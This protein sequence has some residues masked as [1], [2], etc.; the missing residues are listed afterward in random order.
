VLGIFEN[1]KLEGRNVNVEV[2][3]EGAG[4][5]RG[6]RRRRDDKSFGNKSKDDNFRGDRK[7]DSGK[8]DFSKKDGSKFAGGG[9]RRSGDFKPQGTGG[10]RRRKE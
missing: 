9:K 8:R 1:F 7:K 3:S 4:R 6:N 5:D 10:R 2:S